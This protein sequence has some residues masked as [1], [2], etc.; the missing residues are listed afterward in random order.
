M[1]SRLGPAATLSRLA[2]VLVLAASTSAAAEPTAADEWL[3][4]GL[5]RYDAGDYKGAIEAFHAGNDLDPRAQFLFAIA[6]A[7]RRRGNCKEAIIY[8]QKFLATSPTEKQADAARQQ[9]RLCSGTLL[10]NATAPP[11]EPEPEPAPP[12]AP[13]PEP[14][15]R[16]LA[17]WKDPVADVAVG[18]AAVS[19]LAGAALLFAADSAASQAAS[20]DTYDAHA[21]LIDRAESRQMLAGVMLGATVVCAAVAGW[22]IFFTDRTVEVG[23]RF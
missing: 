16:E 20:A 7:E 13:P 1:E 21:M 19:F 4:V 10:E 8:Y 17:W 15:R 5:A 3:D 2:I 9:Q 14:V 12:P 23:G 6:Q 11:P 22:R 18:G